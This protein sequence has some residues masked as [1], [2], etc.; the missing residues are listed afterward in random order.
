[1]NLESIEPGDIYFSADEVTSKHSDKDVVEIMSARDYVK[2]I[3][4]LLERLQKLKS[5][6]VNSDTEETITR[7]GNPKLPLYFTLDLVASVIIA[8]TKEVLHDY[9]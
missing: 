1:M 3:E 8:H 2:S 6:G 9:K 7:T 5:Y 4:N